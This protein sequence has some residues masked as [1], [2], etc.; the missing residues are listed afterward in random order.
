MSVLFRRLI[1]VSLLGANFAILFAALALQPV[2]RTS[3]SRLGAIVNCGAA[4]CGGAS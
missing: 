1:I 2:S 4:R 3:A